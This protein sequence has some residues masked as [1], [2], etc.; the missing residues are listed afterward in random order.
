MFLLLAETDYVADMNYVDLN[1]SPLRKEI[2]EAGAPNGARLLGELATILGINR[3][4]LSHLRKGR[5]LL[6]LL[7]S[8]Y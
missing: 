2:E 8:S 1:Y 5:M 6:C 3:E 7:V 4:L